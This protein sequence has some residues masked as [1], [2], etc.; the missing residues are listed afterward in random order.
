MNGAAPVALS[1]TMRP[2]SSISAGDADQTAYALERAIP[3]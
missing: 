3:S 1:A 2:K